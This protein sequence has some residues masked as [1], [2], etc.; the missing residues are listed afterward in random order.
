[1]KKLILLGF[2]IGSFLTILTADETRAYGYYTNSYSVHRPYRPG[3]FNSNNY[4]YYTNL[5]A[6][7]YGRNTLDYMRCVNSY[8]P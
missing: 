8:K 2:F 7:W 4:Y 1:M 5:C 6:K 3:Y